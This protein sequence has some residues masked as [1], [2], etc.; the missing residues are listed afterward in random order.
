[1]ITFKLKLTKKYF[2]QELAITNHKLKQW[3]SGLNSLTARYYYQ[4]YGPIS[5]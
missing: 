5:K 4:K 3:R 1:M 2:E